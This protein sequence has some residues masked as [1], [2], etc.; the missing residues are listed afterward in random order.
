MTDRHSAVRLEALG[1][2]DA[3]FSFRGRDVTVPLDVDRWPAALVRF[4][5]L[6]AVL[7]LLGDQVAAVLGARAVLDDARELSE[8]M[9]TAVGITHL[10]ESPVSPDN[11]FGA[12]PTLLRILDDHEP[13]VELDL[14]RLGVDYRDRW[15][16][17]LTLRQIWVYIRRS[18]ST[19]AVAIADNDGRHVW[20]ESDFIGAGV[21]QA[22]TGQV[23]PGRPLKPDELAKALEAVQAAAAHEAKLREREA[24]YASPDNPVL[25]AMQ[26]AEENRRRELGLPH[27]EAAANPHPGNG[28]RSAD[29]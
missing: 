22:I 13:D 15:R 27:G 7:V 21:Y 6:Q 11:W 2:T 9:A 5:P 8:A 17:A 1:A 20:N 3:V 24:R 16:G 25:A 10:P 29:G 23:Y 18:P 28:V 26:Q 19:S 12:V 4:D 14:Q